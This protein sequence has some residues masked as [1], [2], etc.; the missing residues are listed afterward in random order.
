MQVDRFYTGWYSHRNP[1]IVPMKMMGR[2]VIQLYDA[3]KDGLNMELSNRMTLVRRPG[4]SPV[5]SNP[6]NGTPLG[7]YTFKPTN[8]PGQLYN[9]VDTTEDIEWLQSNSSQPPQ[10]LLQKQTK[11]QANFAQVAAYLYIAGDNILQKWDGP[12]GA[13]GVTRWGIDITAPETSTGWKSPS[14]SANWHL[15]TNPSAPSWTDPNSIVGATPLSKSTSRVIVEGAGPRAGQI[16]LLNW[17]GLPNFG[18]TSRYL[19]HITGTMY[20]ALV[21]DTDPHYPTNYPTQTGWFIKNVAGNPWDVFTYDQNYAIKHWITE[22]G[23]A[24]DQAYCKSQGYATCWTY[25]RGYKRFLN[26]LPIMPRFFTPGSTVTIDTPAP[27]RL[28][29]TVN[30]E[31]SISAVI[32][33][34]P[35]RGVTTGPINLGWG[36]SLDTKPR[37]GNAGPAAGPTPTI[38]NEYYYTQNK[39]RDRKSVV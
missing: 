31:Q 16:D 29:R 38:K 9:L 23:D 13:Q 4:W 10:V 21:L 15:P 12:A 24:P 8:F 2:M 30:C 32:D 1:L 18:P 7:F 11:T 27:N 35:V 33:L 17:L 5:N 25:P 6:V 34:G 22:N 36:G 19:N 20:E 14:S 37:P 28:N 26:P 3:I 39:S